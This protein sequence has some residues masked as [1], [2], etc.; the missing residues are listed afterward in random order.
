MSGFSGGAV[1]IVIGQ[2][3]NHKEAWDTGLYWTLGW[4][5]MVVA[6]CGIGFLARRG[7]VAI[8]YAPF[9]VQF[10]VMMMKTGGGNMWP[11]G[12]VF[13]ALLGLSGV[14][15][16]VVGSHLGKRI[17]GPADPATDG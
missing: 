14:A 13:M 16:A 5:A 6:A 8:G 17:L 11:L 7:A 4:P 3:T 12:L 15:G 9:A 10:V 2:L 1:E